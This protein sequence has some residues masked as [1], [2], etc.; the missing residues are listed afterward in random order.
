MAKWS[1]NLQV[2]I[3]VDFDDIRAEDHEEL[4]EAVMEKVKEFGFYDLYT[5]KYVSVQDTKDAKL[6]NWNMQ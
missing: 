6:T 5:G 3:E 4:K 2:T 1:G